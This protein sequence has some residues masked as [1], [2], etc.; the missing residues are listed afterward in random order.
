MICLIG[1]AYRLRK[2]SLH[3]IGTCKQTQVM[4][5]TDALKVQGSLF[6]RGPGVLQIK[7]ILKQLISLHYLKSHHLIK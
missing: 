2:P 4:D 3:E 5:M 1:S 6:V 7:I